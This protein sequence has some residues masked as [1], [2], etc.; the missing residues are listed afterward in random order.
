MNEITNE[1]NSGW[2]FLIMFC[3]LGLVIAFRSWFTSDP[4]DQREV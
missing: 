4:D 3:L 1:L 2:F